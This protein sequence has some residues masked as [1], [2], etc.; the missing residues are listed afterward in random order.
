MKNILMSNNK[1]DLRASIQEILSKIY[2]S[3]TEIKAKT[4]ELEKEVVTLTGLASN[5][6]IT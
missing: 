4:K 3:S 6:S 5:L 1:L 2:Y